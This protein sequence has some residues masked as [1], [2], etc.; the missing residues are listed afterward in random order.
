MYG[1]STNNPITPYFIDP[2]D[3]QEHGLFRGSLTDTD[4]REGRTNLQVVNVEQRRVD[5]PQTVQTYK[6]KARTFRTKSS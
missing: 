3:M 6:S 1:P 5:E 4:T 2:P